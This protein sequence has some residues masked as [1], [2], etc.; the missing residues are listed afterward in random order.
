MANELT[1]AELEEASRSLGDFVEKLPRDLL[2]TRR[3]LAR[4]LI[5]S[6]HEDK[7][8]IRLSEAAKAASAKCPSWKFYTDSAGR[9]A[10]RSYGVSDTES[11]DPV[12]HVASAH[13]GMINLIVGGVSPEHLVEVDE[14]SPRH[15]TL[16][17]SCGDPSVFYDP[18]GFATIDCG[19]SE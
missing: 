16:I 8:Y 4:K 9:R 3:E 18:L 13:P 14:W 1:V 10:Y 15:E 2:S 5:L 17:D 6:T 11:G 12:V 7:T 19:E